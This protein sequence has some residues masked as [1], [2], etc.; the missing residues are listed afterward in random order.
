MISPNK[1]K[2]E[3]LSFSELAIGGLV[4]IFVA[5]YWVVG[6]MARGHFQMEGGYVLLASLL[7]LTGALML[8]LVVVL[9]PDNANT[10]TFTGASMVSLSKNSNMTSRTLPLSR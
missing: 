5:M 2:T 4:A 3:W 1:M 10:T 8:R 6:E 7:I 9:F